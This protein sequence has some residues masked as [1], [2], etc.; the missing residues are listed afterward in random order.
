MSNWVTFGGANAGC[1]QCSV[2][3][4]VI[5]MQRHSPNSTCQSG[6]IYVRKEL[7]GDMIA[8]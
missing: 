8:A 7:E 6:S 1:V 4:V 3:A 2:H 5:H